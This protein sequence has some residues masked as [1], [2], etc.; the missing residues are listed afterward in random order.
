MVTK[1]IATICSKLCNK[2]YSKNC[3][4]QYKGVQGFWGYQA[5]GLQ[6][7]VRLSAFRF[8]GSPEGKTDALG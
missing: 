6:V 7:S 8:P 4:C 5:Q 1:V 2:V 3:D